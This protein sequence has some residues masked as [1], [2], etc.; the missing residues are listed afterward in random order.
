MET[1]RRKVRRMVTK[2]SS[3]WN[4]TVN[5]SLGK[6]PLPPV[7]QAKL[8]KAN[9]TL[10]RVGLPVIE[11]HQAETINDPVFEEKAARARASLEKFGLPEGWEKR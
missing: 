8:D 9:E 2:S 4:V 1:K 10:A 7:I 5:P 3:E 6:G 11:Q